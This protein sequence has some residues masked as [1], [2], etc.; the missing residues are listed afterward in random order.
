[1]KDGQQAAFRLFVFMRAAKI[2]SRGERL[3]VR[4]KGRRSRGRRRQ[5]K[6]AVKAPA[7]R[8]EDGEGRC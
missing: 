3:E 4:Q 7:V 5:E 8:K 6:K 2:I 1:M